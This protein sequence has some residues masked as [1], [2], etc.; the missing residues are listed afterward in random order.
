[1]DDELKALID[2]KTW[3]I[4]D[5]PK[6]HVPV[7]C[8]WVYKVKLQADGQ[9]E[10]FKARLVAKGFSQQEGIDYSDTFSSVAKSVTIRA[11]MILAAQQYLPL[12][13]LDVNNA[14]L[15]RDLFEEVYMQIPPGLGAKN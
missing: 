4:V 13:H 2:N 1:M 5:L 8:K 12:L 7:G 9:V 10:R 6:E 11:F 3:V 15:N 14:F